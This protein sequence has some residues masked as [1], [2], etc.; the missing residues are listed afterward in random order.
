MLKR[1]DRSKQK[2][3]PIGSDK[4]CRGGQRACT[5]AFDKFY[6]RYFAKFVTDLRA[7]YGPGPLEP[8][9]VAQQAFANLL[10]RGDFDDVSS[11]EN[12]VWMSARNIIVSEARKK[13]V[14]N[15]SAAEALTRFYGADIDTFDPER[16]FM[17]KEE[18]SRIMRTLNAMPVRRRRI[19]LLNRVQGLTP[20]AIARRF[21][22]GRTTVVH[23]IGK[24]SE[25]LYKSL[26]AEDKSAG[27]GGNR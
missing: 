4:D 20:A 11:P 19:F 23:H 10:K 18:L 25:E 12:F 26:I 7:A 5:S 8:E 22:V 17:A 24:A 15:D 16:V 1:L 6:Q 21:G 2:Q 13:K 9:E 27:E 3:V 14:R